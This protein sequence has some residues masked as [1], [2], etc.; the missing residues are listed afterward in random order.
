MRTERRLQMKRDYPLIPRRATRPGWRAPR[1][2][3]GLSAHTG[4]EAE[5]VRIEPPARRTCM[6]R[7][8]RKASRETGFAWYSPSMVRLMGAVFLYK[9][10]D[11]QWVL[12][13]LIDRR[14]KGRRLAAW[15]DLRLMGR[16]ILDSCRK[17]EVSMQFWT[18]FVDGQPIELEMDEDGLAEVLAAFQ[19]RLVDRKTH[20]IV[21]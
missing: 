12:A 17:V 10:T 21:L 6:C 16:V 9:T 7:K 5:P 20:I 15:K 13:T 3:G 19:A 11:G 14:R 1:P 2:S 4:A 18:V 8:C